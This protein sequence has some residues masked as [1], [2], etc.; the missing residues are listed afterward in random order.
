[1]VVGLG[2]EAV[3]SARETVKT[4]DDLLQGC[5]VI[6][7]GAAANSDNALEAGVC[8][9]AIEALNWVAPGLNDDNIRAC[10]PDIVTTKQMAET[11][12]DYLQQ[13]PAR[14]GEPFQGLVLEALAHRWPC[15]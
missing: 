8:L 1:M 2:G 14:R 7:E 5:K 12:V 4:G 3:T 15:P 6:A 10:I 9:G 13:D 11:I